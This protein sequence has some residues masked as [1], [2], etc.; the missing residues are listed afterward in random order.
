MIFR[1]GAHNSDGT[2]TLCSAAYMFRSPNLGLES[3]HV[4]SHPNFMW[5]SLSSDENNYASISSNM[6]FNSIG[7]LYQSRLRNNYF[8]RERC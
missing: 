7:A 6:S 2:L 1:A 5:G 8:L 3:F 4:Q